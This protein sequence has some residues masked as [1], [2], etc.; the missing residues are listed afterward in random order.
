MER[1]KY[2]TDKFVGARS[3]HNEKAGAA[4][5][6]TGLEGRTLEERQGQVRAGGT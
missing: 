5:A 2:M 3:A 6:R 4:R 1:L